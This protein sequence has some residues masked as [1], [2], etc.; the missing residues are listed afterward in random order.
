[1]T[2]QEW[3]LH[4]LRWR[5]MVPGMKQSSE[6]MRARLRRH[7]G[8]KPARPV[9]EGELFTRARTSSPKCH[10]IYCMTVALCVLAANTDEFDYRQAVH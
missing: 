1:M 8:P 10:L 3:N 9:L 7:E 2:R 6:L 4:G 5:K